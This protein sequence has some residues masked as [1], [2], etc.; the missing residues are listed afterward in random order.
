MSTEQHQGRRLSNP[1]AVEGSRTEDLEGGWL[2]LNV[3]GWAGEKET[4]KGSEI[5]GDIGAV[6]Q[7]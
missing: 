1:R 5:L 6:E 2:A 3:Y 4:T 7:S